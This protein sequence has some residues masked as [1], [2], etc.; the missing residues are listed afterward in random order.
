VTT[1]VNHKGEPIDLKQQMADGARLRYLE[2]KAGVAARKP[3]V[4]NG[5]AAP[6]GTGPAGETCKTCE[7]KRTLGNYG[8]KQFI[9]CEL[10]RST[11]TGGEGTDIL[12]RSPACNKWRQRA[13]M[14]SSASSSDDGSG[15]DAG[16]A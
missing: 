15:T 7:H 1:F 8:G 10:R 16:S 13:A 11:W 2:R 14:A 4:K 6:P 5:Y 12:A 3:T 9:K